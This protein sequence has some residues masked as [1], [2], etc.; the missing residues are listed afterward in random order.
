METKMKKV[1]KFS[2]SI[3]LKA[4]IIAI[5]SLV[6]LIPSLMVQNLIW[7]R[8]HRSVETIE[9]INAKWSHAQT[10]CAPVLSIPYTTSYKTSDN[11]TEYQHHTLNV[12]PEILNIE[13]KLYPEERHYGIYKTILYKSDIELSGEFD[14]KNFRQIENS[15]IHW[16]KAYVRLGVSDLRGITNNINFTFDNNQYEAE[17]RG[18]NEEYLGKEL[19]V[20]L[21][22]SLFE[23]GKETIA[24]HCKLNLN[25]SGSINF[26]PLGKTTNVHVSGAW[27]APGYIGNF[28]PETTDTEGFDA[29]WNVLR[30]NRSIPDSWTD[31]NIAGFYDSTFGVNLVNTVDHYQQNMRSAKYALMFIALTFVVFFFVEILTRKRIHPIQYFLVGVALILFYT[32]LLSIS[33]Q[34]NF[35][36]AYVIA[37]VATIGLI[38]TYAHSI[39]KNKAQSAT[40]AF[41]LIL[42]YVFLYVVLQLEDIALLIGSVGLFIILGIIMYFSRKINW[43]KQEELGEAEE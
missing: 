39:F 41:V 38:T 25:G 29:T 43:Y 35:G 5:L 33:E 18:N 26:I 21:A 17:A 24:F 28:S 36:L 1:E 12:T 13:T 37:S 16:D 10:I 15:I 20:D 6:L 32:L 4:V 31:N 30:Y 34:L 3:T 14:T 27:D 11:K 19:L 9:R 8:Q 2:Q 22:D 40:L 23:S 7:E 42:L